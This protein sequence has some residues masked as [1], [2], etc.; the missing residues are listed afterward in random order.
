[1]KCEGNVIFKSVEKREGGTFKTSNGEV[2]NYPAAYVVKF[3]ENVDGSISERKAKF[4]D[5][6]VALYTKFKTLEPYT[7]IKLVGNVVFQNS[8]CKL[9]INDFD[10]IK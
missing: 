1:M 6:N 4:S 2:L 9:E 5:T 7:K 3:D 10:I 8:G